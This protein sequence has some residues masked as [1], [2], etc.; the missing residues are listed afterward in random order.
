[1]VS[2]VKI[3]Q[4]VIH[5]AVETKGPEVCI[6]PTLTFL[7]LKERH[8]IQNS[9]YSVCLYC[10]IRRSFI[11]KYTIHK[12]KP[13]Y[14]RINITTETDHLDNDQRMTVMYFP[15]RWIYNV[16]KLKQYTYFVSK[17]SP[18]DN[19]KVK[20]FNNPDKSNISDVTNNNVPYCEQIVTELV[21]SIL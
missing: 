14:T 18:T 2:S 11:L 1:V 15:C 10:F 7:E 21:Q 20:I 4:V 3:T 19:S 12:S 17:Q 9:W 5:R 6:F 13:D 8:L 16:Q